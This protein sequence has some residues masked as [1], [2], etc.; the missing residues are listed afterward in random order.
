VSTTLRVTGD[1]SH[2]TIA[3]SGASDLS[4]FVSTPAATSSSA[5]G[6]VNIGK[7]LLIPMRSRTRGFLDA[8]EDSRSHNG[9]LRTT[10]E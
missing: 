8:A 3:V 10:T 7:A 4:G 6:A 5:T 9:Y 2:A 1:G